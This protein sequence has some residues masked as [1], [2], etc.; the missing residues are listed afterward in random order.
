MIFMKRQS[1]KKQ[2]QQETLRVV[3]TRNQTLGRSTGN[4]QTVV[5][6]G[7]KGTVHAQI[8]AAGESSPALDVNT[9]YIVYFNPFVEGIRKNDIIETADGQKLS[10]ILD[11]NTHDV[12]RV[13][14]VDFDSQLRA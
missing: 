1:R 10:V 3:R 5:H 14:C 11:E 2:Q 9:R 4:N 7:V 13:H 8:P 12:Q 6:E